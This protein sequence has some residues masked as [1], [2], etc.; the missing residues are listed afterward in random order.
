MDRAKLMTEDVHKYNNQ[1]SGF[2]ALFK[3]FQLCEQHGLGQGAMTDLVKLIGS[4]M[5]DKV[6]PEWWPAS[7][8]HV[9]RLL[10][11]P[12]FKTECYDIHNF[13]PVCEK[14]FPLLQACQY[15]DS[16]HQICWRNG[17]DGKR[18]RTEGRSVIPTLQAYYKKPKLIFRKF[19][20]D[21]VLMEALKS[22]RQRRVEK[23]ETVLEWED[24]FDGK[25]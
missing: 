22:E 11:F 17:C 2:V 24:W 20:E 12:D 6:R 14:R 25:W 16:A 4:I 5:G 21:P 15:K 13:C 7:A 8:D 10:E 1:M 9:E 19:A 23:M 3:S 18:F